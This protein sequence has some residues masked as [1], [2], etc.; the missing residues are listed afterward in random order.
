MTGR[1]DPLR[2]ATGIFG[3]TFDPIHIAH[4]AVA[5]AARD[6]F[7]LRRVL[8]I[9]AAQPPHKPGGAIT[10]VEHRLAMVEAAVAANPAFEVSRIEVDRAG[11]SY[12]V[13]TLGALCE[14]DPADHLA[15][16]LS[17]ESYSEL[18]TWHEPR[19]I[20][21][22]ADLIVAPRD[23]Y[24][25]ADPNLVP[26]QFP[27]APAAIAFLDGPHIR[28]SASEIRG[29]AAEGRSVRYLVPDAVA[30]YIGDHG[31]YQDD[32]RDHRT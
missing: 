13:D 14:A 28:L 23:G 17:A 31:L 12:T 7:G 3:G 24:A 20:L 8:F 19:R 26:S 22:L 10:P 9:P 21:D 2:G 25:D 29:R 1:A 18:S 32:R 15:L 5:E 6:T 30:A 4:L 16:I 11:P 27:A